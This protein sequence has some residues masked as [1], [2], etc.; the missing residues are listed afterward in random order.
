VKITQLKQDDFKLWPYF[1]DFFIKSQPYDLTKLRSPH[2]KREKIRRT[3]EFYMKNCI[4]YMAENDSKIA[5]AVFLDPSKSY[6]DVSFLFGIRENFSSS[7]L[8][9]TLH[10]IFDKAITTYNK[11]YIK[12]EIR[13]KYKVET[14]KKW[15][16]RYDKTAIIFNDPPNT[17]VWCKSNRMNAKFKVVGTNNTTEH[18]IEKKASLGKVYP[19]KNNPPSRLRELIFE[20]GIYILDEKKVDFLADRVLIHGFLSD[21]QNNVGRVAL[22]FIPQK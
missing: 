5:A 14:Y 10:D 12:S 22:E 20:D 9:T 6:F 11:N 17:V 15:I 4:T 19:D 3:F 7:T 8:I 18:L 13:R 2:L 21:N 16:E 1:I